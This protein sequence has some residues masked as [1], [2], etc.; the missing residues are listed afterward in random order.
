MAHVLVIEDNDDMRQLLCLKLTRQGVSV[1]SAADGKSAFEMAQ[2]EPPDFVFVDFT[3][4]DMAGDEVVRQM[5]AA[6]ANNP[7][8]V[9]VTGYDTSDIQ[10]QVASVQPC[11]VL[12]KPVS[13][14]ALREALGTAN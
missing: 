8:F 3:L 9:I 2:A 1:A 4:P 13:T 10:E 6:S 14:S 5:R 7:T 11:R 12:T